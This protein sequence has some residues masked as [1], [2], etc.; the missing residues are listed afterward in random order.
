MAHRT[1]IIF[2][3]TPRQ[4]LVK[5]RLARDIGAGAATRWYRQNLAATLRRLGLTKRWECRIIAA[6]H[7][8]AAWP[9]PKPWRFSHQARGDLGQRMLKALRSA[10]KGPTVLIGSDIPGI[11]PQHIAAAFS[12]LERNDAVFGPSADGGYWLVGFSPLYR[13]NPFT[14]VRWSTEWALE[15]T[16]AGFRPGTMIGF[17]AEMR[18][19][20]EASDLPAA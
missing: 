9:W 15:D 8:A 19:V 12:A 2:A 13:G 17:A 11:E 3:K 10:T 4:G 18:D 6:P 16:L 5:S 1:L 14:D 20:D 7:H